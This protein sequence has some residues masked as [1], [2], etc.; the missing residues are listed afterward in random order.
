MISINVNKTPKRVEK[1][2]SVKRLL[3]TL[4]QPSEGIAVAVNHHVIIQDKW[5]TTFLQE[6]DSILIIQAAQGG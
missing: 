4:Q 1:N 5:E 2:I 3:F 6:N